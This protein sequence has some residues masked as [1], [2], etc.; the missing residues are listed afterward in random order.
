MAGVDLV[1]RHVRFRVTQHGREMACVVDRQDGIGQA[2]GEEHAGSGQVGGIR[3]L[4][5]NHRPQQHGI[6]QGAG[7]QQQE[8]GGDVGTIGVTY[9]RDVL[10]REAILLR[11]RDDEVIQFM[12][13]ADQVWRR[14]IA[15]SASGR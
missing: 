6:L 1:M 5:G 9:R 13:A 10:R 15:G 3:R 11:C 12:R 2:A 14:S 7:S 8:A 4:Q